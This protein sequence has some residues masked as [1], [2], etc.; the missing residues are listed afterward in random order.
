MLMVPVRYSRHTYSMI[1]RSETFTVSVPVNKD[2]KKR[3]LPTAV[4]SLV[5]MLIKSKNVV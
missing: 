3:N 2:L 4:Q 5:V 1:D